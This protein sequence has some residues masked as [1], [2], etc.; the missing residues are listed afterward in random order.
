MP[1]QDESLRAPE[2]LPARA[3]ARGERTLIVASL[4]A[5]LLIALA[6]AHPGTIIA[7]G[8]RSPLLDPLNEAAKCNTAWSDGSAYVG[9]TN[10][11]FG[12]ALYLLIYAAFNAVFG[13]SYGQVILAALILGL[14]WLGAFRLCRTVGLT[15]P[16][17]C[18]AAWAYTL[19]PARPTYLVVLPSFDMMAAATPWLFNALFV[20][21][22]PARR[23]RARLWIAA[24]AA[25]V[26]AQLATTPQI[27][28]AMALGCLAWAFLPMRL[29]ADAREYAL[30]ALKTLVIASVASLWWALPSAISYFSGDVTRV[31][32]ASQNGW[33]FGNA[34][35]LN[36]MRWT[37]SWTWR[38]L[39]YFPWSGVS[40]R[41]APLYLST[42]TLIGGVIA[43]LLF[44]SGRSLR[45][46]RFCGALAL[47]LLFLAKG[48]HP[49][50]EVL[51]LWFFKI[52]G[53]FLFI[54][55]A[56]LTI[57]AAL[58]AALCLGI[59]LE[60]APEMF[61]N[62]P[63]KRLLSGAAIGG[64]IVSNL[65]VITGAVFHESSGFEP[66]MHVRVPA[67]WFDIARRINR[68][69]PGG[70]FV[71]PAD[72]T[73][74]AEYSWGFYGADTLARDLLH[75]HVLLPGATRGYVLPH[76]QLS[77]ERKLAS[78]LDAGSP[79]VA[80]ALRDLGIRY[81]IYRNDVLLSTGFPF[82]SRQAQATFAAYP[83][84]RFGALD[85]YDLGAPPSGPLSTAFAA[86]GEDATPIEPGDQ[87]E[88]R[89][90]AERVPRVTPSKMLDGAVRLT[91]L[92][93]PNRQASDRLIW[94]SV[95]GPASGSIVAG[96]YRSQL[97]AAYAVDKTPNS[98]ETN[99]YGQLQ[100][101]RGDDGLP[102][103]RLVG[104][105]A[106]ERGELYLEVVVPSARIVHCEVD[107]GVRPRRAADYTLTVN[108][109]DMD[110]IHVVASAT[111]VW[112]RIP[113]VRL[114]PGRNE[115][116]ASRSS[117]PLASYAAL[118]PPRR[119]VGGAFEPYEG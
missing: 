92:Q 34:S 105:V 2:S 63:L 106:R 66:A 103:P 45:I 107:I 50:F 75:R 41:S 51:N 113:G 5:I 80:P 90:L 72:P 49:P 56:G 102:I 65:A 8:D 115:L 99:T 39:D 15:A 53:M 9:Q 58:C 61:R 79:L 37:A 85:L 69:P 111:P 20:A 62:L 3:P 89:A 118:L 94:R 64:L 11:C 13:L 25:V 32:N 28:L 117:Y 44:A 77:I 4:G 42:F 33:I 40:D 29:A 96:Q 19:N 109:R 31:T 18:I 14:C 97:R 54:E 23:P 7:Q 12:V 101:I 47:F 48:T 67:Y 119:F 84:E 52:P 68:A 36:E 30:W 10:A 6:W 26:G 88:L 110:R 60:S 73:Q 82:S 22:D 100:L 55:P 24:I 91:E 95:L 86:I 114:L 57:V 43:G 76:A 71:L 70:A 98:T 108:G 74:Y 87:L 59:A 38:F 81:V 46:V 83:V 116:V 27:I 1:A 16:F 104:R 35:L 112:L 78:M 21:V 17:A 93:A